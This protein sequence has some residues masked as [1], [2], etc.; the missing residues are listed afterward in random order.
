MKNVKLWITRTS[1]TFLQSY[2]LLWL[3]LEPVTV[4]VE[5]FPKFNIKGYLALVIIS[6]LSAL[7][8]NRKKKKLSLIL[9][10]NGSEI[11]ISV[12]DIFEAQSHIAIG[13]NDVFDT[14]LGNVIKPSSVQGQLTSKNYQSDSSRLDEEINKAIASKSINGILDKTKTEGKN[15]R[16]PIGTTLS[17]GNSRKIYL[18]AYAQMGS[19]IKCNSSAD[20]IWHSLTELWKEVRLTAQGEKVSIPII[21]SD[22]ART[23]LSRTALIEMIV[24]SFIA[25]TNT[26]FVSK[27]LN[28]VVHS[29]DYEKIDMI[30]LE[31]FLEVADK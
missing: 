9:N 31:Q 12:G 6:G 18:C 25:A 24:I 8:I 29:S 2:G 3:I 15:I 19:N 7:Y 5:P 22:L 21:G 27:E 23:G 30:S 14:S 4:I 11:N 17:L 28:I 13:T 16:Y 1:K 26:E 20:W 10:G